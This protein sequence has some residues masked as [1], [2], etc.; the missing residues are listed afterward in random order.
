MQNRLDVLT[1]WLILLNLLVL[2]CCKS[3]FLEP[4]VCL[5]NGRS[6]WCHVSTPL[7]LDD[8]PLVI[9][10]NAILGFET[11]DFF[12]TF[13]FFSDHLCSSY[14]LIWKSKLFFDLMLLSQFCCNLEWF[15]F[16]LSIRSMFLCEHLIVER[17]LRFCVISCG[18]DLSAKIQS[19]TPWF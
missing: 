19:F 11:W 6:R 9:I 17:R 13:L 12:Q 7:S 8:W 10:T 14:F 3:V 1:D 4:R 15:L 16:E 18:Y 2:V 5:K